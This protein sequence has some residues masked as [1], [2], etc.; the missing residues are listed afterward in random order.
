MT[1]LLTHYCWKRLSRSA[2]TCRSPAHVAVAYFSSGAAKLLPLC[3]DSRLVVDASAHAIRSGQT[4]PDDL[5]ALVDRGVRVFSVPNLHAKVFVFGS[6]AF[7]GSANVSN[8][9]NH[10]LIEAVVA[11]SDRTVVAS[12]KQFVRDH[13]LHELGPVELDRLQKLYRPPKY[14]GGGSRRPMLSTPSRIELPRHHVAVITLD[15][16][17]VGSGSTQKA[18]EREGKR[19]MEYPRTHRLDYF[20]TGSNDKYAVGDMITQITEG[21]DGRQMVSPPGKVTNTRLWR[22]RNDS[23]LFVYIELPKTRRVELSRFVKRVGRGSRRKLLSDDEV[24]PEFA[25]RILA[26]WNR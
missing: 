25:E 7:I 24:T 4:H 9:S 6:E 21:T 10:T 18:G 16:L 15:D 2:R 22:G 20:W 5:K 1:E 26:A 8:R 3:A 17:P 13:C 19:L 11:T 14:T 23:R 12:A